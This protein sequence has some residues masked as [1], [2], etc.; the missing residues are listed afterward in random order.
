MDALFDDALKAMEAALVVLQGQVP[1]P[2]PVPFKESYVYRYAEQSAHQAVIQKLARV[3]SGLHAAELL[4][5]QGF[6]QEQGAM[7]RILDELQEDIIFLV[8]ALIKSDLTS[9]HQ[10]YLAAFYQEEFDTPDDP[11]KST[12]RRPM[13]SR[14]KIR[15]YNSRI[16][17]SQ[18]DP[19]RSVKLSRTLSKTYA[20]F[21]HGASPHIMDMY[22]GFPPR[23]H[24][25]GMLGTPRIEEHWEDLCNYFYR[26]ICVF[27]LAAKGFGNAPLFCGIQ[28]FLNDFE[29]R[30]GRTYVEDE[31]T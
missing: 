22:G 25:S 30:S 7:H 9:L 21:V 10:E 14:K 5:A 24:V 28:R 3:I 12:Q 4:L 1:Q 8:Y 27:G 2:K 6:V 23:F 13:V 11:V 16:E 20:G 19:S 31:G 15:A 18:L 26:G 17:E 29:K